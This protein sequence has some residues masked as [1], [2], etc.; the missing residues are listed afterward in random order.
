M[1]F[2]EFQ[3]QLDELLKDVS[4]LDIHTSPDFQCDQT[5]GVPTSLC[6][7]WSKGKAWLE[8]NKSMIEGCDEKELAKFMD[9]CADFGIRDCHSKEDFNALLKE[10]GEEAYENGALFYDE[11]YDSPAEEESEDESM[12]EANGEIKMGGI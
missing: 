10:L 12:T 7:L 1:K 11:L 3:K 9:E 6:V 2:S 8:P 5:D 4:Q